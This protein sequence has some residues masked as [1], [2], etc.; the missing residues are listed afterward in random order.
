MSRAKLLSVS[1]ER[2]KSYGTVTEFELKPL[3]VVVGRNNSGKSTVI[4]ALL[5]L[6]QTL[7]QTRSD[8]ALHL[9][10]AVDAINLRELTTH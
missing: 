9:E 6:Q 4:Q 8:V 2:F 7:K 10:G 3:T 5:L 1:L